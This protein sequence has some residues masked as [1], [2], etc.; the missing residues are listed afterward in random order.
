M[1]N[2]QS[3]IELTAEEQRELIEDARILQ[4]ASIDPDGLP[5]LVPMW[6][7]FDDEGVLTFTACGSSQKVKNLERNP[8][9]TALTE[10]GDAYDQVLDFSIDGRAEIVRDPHVTA[11][12]LQLV[13]ARY[14][15]RPR[16]EPNA[17]A[18]PPPA[19]Y[20][21]VTIRIH[22]ERVR[23]WYHRKL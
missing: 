1:P 21:R 9:F 11:R 6:F 10:T 18:A 8:R 17:D 22:P 14:G 19:A 2:A 3:R 23:N 12:A 16:P 20:K 4:I 5:H 7:V 15:N 13:G